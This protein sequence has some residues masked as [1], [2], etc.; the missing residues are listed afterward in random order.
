V[1]LWRESAAAAAAAAA[2]NAVTAAAG[3]VVAEAGIVVAVAVGAATGL[4]H[5]AYVVARVV[6]ATCVPLAPTA[7]ISLT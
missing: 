6:S 4:Q 7:Q 2:V 5:W 3:I 1:A